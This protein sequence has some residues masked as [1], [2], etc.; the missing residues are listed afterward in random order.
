MH[1]NKDGT[2]ELWSVMEAALE[3]DGPEATADAGSLVRAFVHRIESYDDLPLDRELT[4]TTDALPGSLVPLARVN[5]L[6]ELFTMPDGSLAT[7]ER[8][9][10]ALGGYGGAIYAVSEQP[11]GT[12]SK[13]RLTTIKDIAGKQ[14]PWVGNY[15][16]A[17]TGPSMAELSGDP[18]MPGHLVLFIA[19]DNFGADHQ[20]GTQVLAVRVLQE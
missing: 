16:G 13:S 19:D 10:T 14:L 11:D 20:R 12:I 5:S 6:A 17:C 18:D 3:T 9:A 8:S 7:L 4:Y 15:E 1:T 2:R